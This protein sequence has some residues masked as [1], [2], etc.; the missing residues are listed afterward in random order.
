MASNLCF[1][2]VKSK[3]GAEW[4]TMYPESRDNTT[5]DVKGKGKAVDNGN[6]NIN[7][8]NTNMNANVTV[9][10]RAGPSA[11]NNGIAGSTMPSA[12]GPGVR[13]RGK[14]VRASG[15]RNEVRQD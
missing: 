15:L 12:S 2:E 3:H 6:A 14:K 8:A 9:A 5:V 4:T 7:Q 13:R 10:A 1:V 11:N